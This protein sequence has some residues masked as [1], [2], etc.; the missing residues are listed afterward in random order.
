MSTLLTE[1]QPDYVYH[2]TTAVGIAVLV[3]LYFFGVWSRSYVMPAEKSLPIRR[4]LVASVP[5]GFVTMGLYARSSF[6]T[7]SLESADLVF[8]VAVMMGYAI[9]F[10]M[11]S[12]ETLE[13]M[14]TTIK[15]PIAPAGSAVLGDAGSAA[16]LTARPAASS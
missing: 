12:R 16:D 9:I 11:L 4:Q 13:R 10:G 2:A 6:P 1:P 8:N 15:P 5:V 14:M 7:M 3:A